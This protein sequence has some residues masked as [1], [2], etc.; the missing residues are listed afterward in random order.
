MSHASF[1]AL[2]KA[3]ADGSCFNLALKANRDAIDI[4]FKSE[5]SPKLDKTV[6]ARLEKDVQEANSSDKC[7]RARL[8]KDVREAK[9]VSRAEKLR[10]IRSSLSNLRLP[11]MSSARTVTEDE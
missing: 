7:I 11:L 1:G 5:F 3:G 10:A 6:R 9:A 4:S 2:L 8:E